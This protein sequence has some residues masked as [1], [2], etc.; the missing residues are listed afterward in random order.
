M[1]EK[2]K[3][4]IIGVGAIGKVHANAY[5]STGQVEIAAVCDVDEAK[6]AAIG[7]QFKVKERF[8][9]YF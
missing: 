7:E 2:L 5:A 6:L 3:V 4:G 8:K 1:S 9:D